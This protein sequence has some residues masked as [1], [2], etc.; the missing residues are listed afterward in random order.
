V[1]GRRSPGW[2]KVKNVR[3][4][5]AVIGG[6]LPGDGGRAGRLGALA[7]GVYDGDELRF[8]GKVGT[9][10]TDA[11]LKRLQGLLEPLERDT[12]PFTGTQP[13][14]L[15]RFVEPRLVAVVEYTE[16]TRIGTF[17]HPSYKGLRDDVDPRDVA[18]ERADVG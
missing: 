15:T 17:R 18:M 10:F 2:V 3:R 12:S 9:G 11:E 4:A 6:W 13:P 16:I 1:P 8:A 14:K 5:D 7:L